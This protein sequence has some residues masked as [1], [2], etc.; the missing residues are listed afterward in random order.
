MLD[1]SQRLGEDVSNLQGSPDMNRLYKTLQQLVANIM[2]VQ[3][4]VF[5]TLMKN[6]ILSNVNGGLVVTVQE[7]GK[8]V[9][10]MQV[11]Q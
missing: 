8:R 1:L 10:C 5:S 6:R 4:K 11:P 3:M 7:D 9:K 2:T